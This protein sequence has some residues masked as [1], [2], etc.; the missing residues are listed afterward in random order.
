MSDSMSV[1]EKATRLQF[2]ADR[3]YLSQAGT[4]EAERV[5]NRVHSL[6]VAIGNLR[7]LA[8]TAQF[9]IGRTG[10]RIEF[11]TL[12]QG[13]KE[14]AKH[15]ERGFPSNQAFGNAERRLKSTADAL[16]TAIQIQWK[17]WAADQLAALELSRIAMLGQKQ[18]AQANML[19]KSLKA[20]AVSSSPDI[21]QITGFINQHALLSEELQQAPDVPAELLALLN[22]LNNGGVTL[23]DIGDEEIAL[24]R[25]HAMDRQVELKRKAS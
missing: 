8:K 4:Q 1:L 6:S 25:A 18:Q 19:L 22:R 12:E 3:I 14:L 13:Y 23:A 21:A 2:E 9:L 15:A 7:M 11:S 10:G 17:D 16:A 5:Q 20:S 24:L